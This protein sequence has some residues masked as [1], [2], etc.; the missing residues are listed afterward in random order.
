LEKS[1]IKVFDIA[2]HALL[3]SKKKFNIYAIVIEQL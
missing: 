2:Q 1:E 3:S